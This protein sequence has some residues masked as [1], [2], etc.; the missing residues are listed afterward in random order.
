M[1]DY[2]FVFYPNH[3]NHYAY[4][5][6]VANAKLTKE[7]ISQIEGFEEALEQFARALTDQLGCLGVQLHDITF[8]MIKE[9]RKR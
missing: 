8:T 4:S 6:P 5:I 2:E 7:V 3:D 1:T 9:P